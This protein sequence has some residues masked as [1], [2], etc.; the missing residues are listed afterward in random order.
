M[1]DFTQVSL[2]SAGRYQNNARVRLSVA[3]NHPHTNTPDANANRFKCANRAT[4]WRHVRCMHTAPA[5][6][7]APSIVLIGL[8]GRIG[9]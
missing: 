6:K 4:R 3:I 9:H 5:P 1:F 7:M 8:T 2:S